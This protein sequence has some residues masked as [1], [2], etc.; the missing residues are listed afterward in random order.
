[1]KKIKRPNNQQRQRQKISRKTVIIL[2]ASSI[3]CMVIGLTIFFNLTQVDE[4]KAMN[5]NVILMPDQ[6]FT[7]EKTIAAPVIAKRPAANANTIFIKQAKE[8]PERSITA[9]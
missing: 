5:N 2:C 9:E 3:A 8:L 4:T 1:M 7:N 6:F